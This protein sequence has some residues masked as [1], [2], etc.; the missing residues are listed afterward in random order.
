MTLRL[1]DSFM[2]FPEA[3]SLGGHLGLEVRVVNINEG[4]NKDILE[5]CR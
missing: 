2:E 3:A 1:S 4:Y 5:R